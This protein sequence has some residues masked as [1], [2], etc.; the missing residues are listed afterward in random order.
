MAD[1]HETLTARLEQFARD[2]VYERADRTAEL[3]YSLLRREGGLVVAADGSA[4]VGSRPISAIQDLLNDVAQ[5]TGLAVGLFVDERPVLSS[6][7]GFGREGAAPP[8]PRDVHTVAVVRGDMFSGS[9]EIGERPT[10]VVARPIAIKG[11]PT[12]VILCGISAQEANS[13]L[14][15]LASIEAEIIGLADQV[16]SERQRAVADFL[17]II[18]S[19]AKRIHLLALNASI[20]SAQAGDQGRGFAVVAREI[21]ELAERTRQSTQELENEFLGRAQQQ[22]ERRSGGRGGRAA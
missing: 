7:P 16:Q 13:T 10:L 1:L 5:A 3:V 12:A 22:V 11:Q 14:L 17:K 8:L 21:G 9:I 20:L 4:R 15:G 6:T 18:R 19:I 2:Q